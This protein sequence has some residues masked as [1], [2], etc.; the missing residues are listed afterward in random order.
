MIVQTSKQLQACSI[1][2]PDIDSVQDTFKAIAGFAD[3]TNKTYSCFPSYETLA[4]ITGFSTRTLK[5][6]VKRLIELGVIKS[7]G[8]GYIC[9]RTKLRRQTSNLY[10]FNMPVIKAM[11]ARKSAQL[12]GLIKKTT[13]IIMGHVIRENTTVSPSSVIGDKSEQLNHKHLS[14]KEQNVSKLN[15]EDPK[16]LLSRL[17]RLARYTSYENAK[18]NQGKRWFVA[19]QGLMFKHSSYAHDPRNAIG[20]V[21]EGVGKSIID[22]VITYAQVQINKMGIKHE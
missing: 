21:C 5:R 1:S 15:D 8:R 12:A 18:A 6:H 20:Y 22:S 19:K 7:I 10:I 13:K 16:D 3:F 2:I 4:R 14:F 11:V 17:L 9:N